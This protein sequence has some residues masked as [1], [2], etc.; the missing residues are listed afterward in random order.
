MRSR[1][2]CRRR[3][4][5]SISEL[6]SK[7]SAFAALCCHLWPVWFYNIF[8]HHHIKATIFGKLY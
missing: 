3:K 7:Q 1:N 5:V 4:A 8:P 2:Y 6:S